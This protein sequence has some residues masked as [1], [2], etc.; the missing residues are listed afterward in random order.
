MSVLDMTLNNLMVSE[1]PVMLELLGM[2]CTPLF[3]WLPDS[4][5]PGVVVSDRVLSMGHI[6]LNCV[7]MLN[8][9]ALNRIVL[10]FKLHIYVKLFWNRTVFD[11]ETVLMLN[12]IFWNRTVYMF[13]N[14][15]GIHNLQWLMCHKTK[16]NQTNLC[17]EVRNTVYKISE[18]TISV[19]RSLCGTLCWTVT[20]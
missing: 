14:G 9:V 6:E 8:W 12:W 4:L 11:T 13:K 3:I 20:S 19:C 1:G 17:K 10:T 16:S 2:L 5:W 7:F 18:L 15:F